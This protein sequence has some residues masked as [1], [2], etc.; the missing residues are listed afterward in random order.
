MVARLLLY[1]TI[2]TRPRLKKVVQLIDSAREFD[3]I[4]MISWRN[5]KFCPW[6]QPLG[7]LN[8]A[9]RFLSCGI[10]PYHQT[11]N[12]SLFIMCRFFYF[13]FLISL[14][15]I[16]STNGKRPWWNF[17]DK[18]IQTTTAAG[19]IRWKLFSICCSFYCSVLLFLRSFWGGTWFRW[20]IFIICLDFCR[21]CFHLDYKK[22][23]PIH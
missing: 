13:I 9:E 5:E 22:K 7:F 20:S 4:A 14:S 8:R 10:V 11:K 6:L 21:R 19:T 18:A 17:V 16:Y 1:S 23:N 15:M 12:Q 2:G 3:L